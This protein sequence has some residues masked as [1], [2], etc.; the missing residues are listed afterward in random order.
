V[1]AAGE[2]WEG[3]MIKNRD[4]VTGQ[5]KTKEIGERIFW[6]R[7]LEM[8]VSQK[9]EPSIFFRDHGSFSKERYI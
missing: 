7:C 8:F 5:K 2:A 3:G 9:D 6:G 4:L 1:T